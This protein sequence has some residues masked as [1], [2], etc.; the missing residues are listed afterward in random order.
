MSKIVAVS[1]QAMA[2]STSGRSCR[3]PRAHILLLGDIES[4]SDTAVNDLTWR[5]CGHP[6]V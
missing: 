3:R 1:L 5:C 2:V 4:S 6:C